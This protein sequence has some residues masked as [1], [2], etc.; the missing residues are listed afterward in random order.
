[1]VQFQQSLL[2]GLPL[3]AQ[4]INTAQPSTFQQILGGAGSVASLLNNLGLGKTPAA[5]T[6]K[7]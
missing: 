3:A 4:N 1:M 5:T 6:P 2:S 7:G